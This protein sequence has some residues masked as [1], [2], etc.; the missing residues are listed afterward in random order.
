MTATMTKKVMKEEEGKKQHLF[1]DVTE[2]PL[3]SNAQIEVTL[4]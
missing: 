2:S 1:T 4:T 3:D